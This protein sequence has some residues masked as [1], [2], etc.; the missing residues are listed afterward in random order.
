[1]VEGAPP[2]PEGCR[3]LERDDVIITPHSAWFSANA[4][5]SLQRLAAME[6]ARALRGDRPKSL[7]N[8]EVWEGREADT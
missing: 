4:L 2:L 8:P 3:L 6:V 5:V 7:L 1:V